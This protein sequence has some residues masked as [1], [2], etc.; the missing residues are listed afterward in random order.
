MNEIL[1]QL[2][3][4]QRLLRALQHSGQG[5]LYGTIIALGI[6]TL[7]TIL[8]SEWLQ[9]EPWIALLSIPAAAV[10]GTIIGLLRPVDTLR[11]ARAMDRAAGSEDRFASAWQLTSHHRRI[12]AGLVME[13][14]LTS[15]RQTRGDSAV[16]LRAP[17]ELKWLPLPGLAL[18]LLFW[19]AP[20]PQL[21]ADV[22]APPEV[23]PQE[24]ADLHAALREQIDELPK[25][26]TDEENE[27]AD[28]LDKLA[29]LLKK[30]PAKKDVLAQIAKLQAD[31]RSRREKLGT[32]DVSMRQAAR[33]LRSST[34]L[35]RFA[36]RA[37]TPGAT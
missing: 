26:Q 22:V 31:L 17:R 27:T 19:L 6:A 5:L 18:V 36:S 33:A 14:A 34:T 25:P 37:G 3:R 30:N 35:Q 12:R 13:D 9:T 4:R 24:W 21:S 1:A 28:Q 2:R 15:V 23:T 8:R 20:G 16:P 11:I 29:T 32:R 7:A 10:V